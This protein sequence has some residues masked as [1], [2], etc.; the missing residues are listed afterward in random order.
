MVRWCPRAKKVFE[1]W[2]IISLLGT[3]MF[4]FGLANIVY[5][6]KDLK[7]ENRKIG[8]IVFL[9]SLILIAVS[10]D[11]ILAKRDADLM[12]SDPE[13]YLAEMKRSSDY[14]WLQALRK[15][16]PDRYA[17]EMKRRDSPGV[18][19]GRGINN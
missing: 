10:M 5:P 8:C 14:E 3:I 12:V 6:M 2:Y 16:Y 13:A 1:M 19:K 15:L 18:Y 7:V 11:N 9:V 4:L 17:A